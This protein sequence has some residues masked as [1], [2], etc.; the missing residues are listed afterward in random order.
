[1]RLIRSPIRLIIHVESFVLLLP[2][3]SKS[4]C[5]Q[6]G[7][8]FQHFSR[9]CVVTKNIAGFGGALRIKVTNKLRSCCSIIT[10]LENNLLLKTNNWQ[11]EIME[12]PA[13][14]CKVLKMAKIETNKYG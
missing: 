3:R 7:R 12:S 9:Y 6:S 4:I 10:I 8:S 1:M 11:M 14:P 5:K 2:D 13:M